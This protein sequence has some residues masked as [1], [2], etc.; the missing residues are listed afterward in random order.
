MA[1]VV[2]IAA[3]AETNRAI[4]KGDRLPW[5]L[6]ADLKRFKR[7]TLGHTVVMGR[8]TWQSLPSQL[9]S[10]LPQRHNIVLSHSLPPRSEVVA[11][12]TRLD[13]V[14]TL[15]AA[16]QEARTPQIFIIGGATVYAQSLRLA[17]RLEL[18]LVE[19]Q[20]E[21]DAFFP[22]YRSLLDQCFQQRYRQQQ[23]G[24]RYESYRRRRGSINA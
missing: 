5:D 8:R 20:Y 6:P 21:G 12:Q 16:L 19:G 1:E 17:D 3:L 11:P 24:F 22:P 9:P 18:T 2:V 13:I 15:Q 4:G 7:L 14:S 23:L 10:A